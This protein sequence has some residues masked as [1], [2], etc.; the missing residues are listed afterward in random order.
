MTKTDF[1]EILNSTPSINSVY[2]SS[3]CNDNSSKEFNIYGKGFRKQS[4]VIKLYK[5]GYSDIVSTSYDV[6]TSTYIKSVFNI[7]LATG[8]KRNISVDSLY[9]SDTVEIV[10]CSLPPYVS[11]I[12]PSY[13]Y[14]DKDHIINIFGGNFTSGLSIKV[15]KDGVQLDGSNFTLFSSTAIISCHLPLK[16]KEAGIWTIRVINPSGKYGYFQDLIC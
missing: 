4:Y 11:W 16:G 1:F 15:I 14:N 7:Y 6:K 8:G 5:A 10:D 9:K 3:V 13:G 12:D 2:P